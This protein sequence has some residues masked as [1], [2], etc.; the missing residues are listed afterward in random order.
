MVNPQLR[1]APRVSVN[2]VNLAWIQLPVLNPLENLSLVDAARYIAENLNL[3]WTESLGTSVTGS[4]GLYA[5]NYNRVPDSVSEAISDGP[6]QY[7]TTRLR[8]SAVSPS[9]YTVENFTSEIA[10]LPPD[11]NEADS[12]FLKVQDGLISRKYV[13]RADDQSWLTQ[14]FT[15]GDELTL[16][17]TLPEVAR[18]P[19]LAVSGTTYR[20][21]RIVEKRD[22]LVS[23]TDQHI[24][25]FPD[26]DLVEVQS[27]QVNGQEIVTSTSGMLS[28]V[29]SDA[30]LQQVP[31]RGPFTAWDPERGT[32]T[33]QR[34]LDAESIVT[35]TY[36]YREHDFTFQGF[37][38]EEGEWRDLDLNPAPG[39]TYDRGRPT[40]EL[41]HKTTFIYL[42]PTAAF[43]TT[44]AN[45]TTEQRRNIYSGLRW[46][47]D[48]LR[49]EMVDSNILLSDNSQP[50]SGTT[51]NRCQ[52]RY[53]FGHSYFGD[54][55]FI[56]DIRQENL[57]PPVDGQKNLSSFPC[58]AIL[59]KIYVTAAS[60]LSSVGVIDTRVA[61]GGIPEAINPRDPRLPGETRR[62]IES[63]WDVEGWDGAPVPLAGVLL[64][65]VP[66][67]LLT[68]SN[69]LPQFS[70]EEIQ[71]IVESNVAA[72]IRVV[73]RFL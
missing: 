26:I 33:L 73:L 63:Y 72:G 6:D 56:S 22:A 15:V 30:A 24:I 44:Q 16:L 70:A 51:A 60:H 52:G 59:A 50:T 64:V 41:L 14:I 10:V 8:T 5:V 25:Q 66:G 58:A 32:V 40:S 9:G 4:G 47:E 42:L 55:Y 71:R 65:E 7:T 69:G 67:D 39:H 1:Y 45:G 13:L 29:S 34:S 3:T 49:W 43:R 23:V 68:G 36:R 35:A 62:K 48:F 12:W 61:G 28:I 17:Y 2:G 27:L 18:I 37:L 54:A 53:T 46:L 21:Q 11:F 57:P 38:D 31:A 20:D 19:S